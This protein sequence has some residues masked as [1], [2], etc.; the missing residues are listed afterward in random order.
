MSIEEV[1]VLCF[2]SSFTLASLC[3]LIY[4]IYHSDYMNSED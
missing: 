4:A 3:L 1:I 2:A